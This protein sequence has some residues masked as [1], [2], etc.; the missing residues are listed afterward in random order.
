[1]ENKKPIIIAHRGASAYAPE[2][3]MA[4]FKKAVEL[5]ADG[6]EFDVK[7]SKDGEMV[8][9]H[10][11]SLERTT[12]GHGRVIETNLKDLRNLDAGSSF[13][14]KF[15]GEKIPLLSEVLEEFSKRLL[16][17]IELTNYSSIRDGLAKKAAYLV[18]QM[19]IENRVLFSS[20]HPYNLFITRR[21]LPNVSVALLALPGKKGWI[22]R[23]NLMRWISPDLIHP[24]YSDVDKGFIEKQHRK[25]RKVNVWTVNTEKQIL[26]LLKD[27]VDGLIT[28]DPSLAKRIINE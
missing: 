20:F 1:M 8:I 13:S 4:A 28:D 7:C 12:N 3:T 16:I 10:D 9:I 21:I 18:K 22:F 15:T 11:Q 5:S 24:Y 17:N 14:S 25:N 27:N 2:N 19:G 26:K 23:S 6:I